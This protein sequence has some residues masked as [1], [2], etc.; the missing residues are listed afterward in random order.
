METPNNVRQATKIDEVKLFY[1]NRFPKIFKAV[2][3]APTE[4]SYEL[5]SSVSNENYQHALILIVSAGLLFVF[6]PYLAVGQ[7][8]EFLRFG[9]FLRI[10]LAAVLCLLLLSG[11]T[12]IIKSISGKADFKNELLTGAVCGIP[13]SMLVAVM[14]LVNLFS[15]RDVME[16]MLRDP[17]SLIGSAVLITL[18]VLYCFLSMITILQQSLRASGTK[19]AMSWY[20]S[21]ICVLLSVYLSVMIVF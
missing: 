1:K 20:L 18:F 3:T 16:H 7:A 8:R 4:G 10:G 5:F 6:L 9:F 12:F 11:A 14:F 19:D 13:L 2:F 21:P 17:Q 15:S